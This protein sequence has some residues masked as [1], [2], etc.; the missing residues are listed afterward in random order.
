MYPR[1]APRLNAL[2]GAYHARRQFRR[3]TLRIPRFGGLPRDIAVMRTEIDQ[4]RSPRGPMIAF[5]RA[6]P[7]FPNYPIT[8]CRRIFLYLPDSQSIMIQSL[9]P[10]KLFPPCLMPPPPEVSG[11]STR[12][13]RWR[14]NAAFVPRRVGRGKFPTGPKMGGM[15]DPR[16][17]TNLLSETLSW[18]ASKTAFGPRATDNHTRTPKLPILTQ[19]PDHSLFG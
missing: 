3:G 7:C 17:S 13:N 18:Q 10:V 14:W 5:G 19:A 16:A 1:F 9:A 6:I 2:P 4:Q 12:A 15:S 8:L 11:R